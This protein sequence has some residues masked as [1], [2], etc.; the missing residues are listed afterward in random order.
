MAVNNKLLSCLKH[1]GNM[2]GI[3]LWSYL[4]VRYESADILDPL[5]TLCGEKIWLLKLK[6]GGSLVKYIY[7]FQ[8]LKLFGKKSTSLLNLRTR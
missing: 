3:R 2:D 4:K 6:D 1:G 7:S 8:G 5:M